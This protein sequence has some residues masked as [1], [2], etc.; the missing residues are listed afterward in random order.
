[1]P[2][3]KR[4]L[5]LPDIHI[6]FEDKRSLAAVEQVM[7]AHPWDEI[8]QIGDF[9]DFNCIS[10]HND[11]RP[12][13]TEGQTIASDFAAANRVLA[14][15]Q[16]IVPKAQITLLEGNHE[17]RI[18]RYLEKYPPLKGQI[19]VPVNLR[20][21]E[22]GIRWVPSWSEGKLYQIGN[23][24]FHHGLYTNDAHAKKMVTHFGVNM[25]YGHTHDIQTYSYPQYGKDRT[26]TGQSL[27][28]LCLPQRYMKGA[29]DKWQQ[30]FAALTFFGDDYFTPNVV[31]V[32]KHRFYFEG[33]VYQG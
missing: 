12:G 29:P 1:M 11:G 3:L 2:K 16:R 32:F 33:K 30:G 28:C 9:L 22:R 18:L 6:P 4:V 7:A 24:Y 26:L 23:A 13:L 27:G 17:E 20:L 21:K 14:R 19:E 5:V 8:V 31:R 10:S 25:F 15:W